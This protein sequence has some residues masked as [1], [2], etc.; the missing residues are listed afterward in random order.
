VMHYFGLECYS[1]WKHQRADD[2]SPE[3]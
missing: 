3:H 2:D 1:K